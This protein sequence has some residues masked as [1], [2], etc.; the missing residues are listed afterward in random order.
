MGYDL[1]RGQTPHSGAFP[2][3]HKENTTEVIFPTTV[4]DE[5]VVRRAKGLDPR[6]KAVHNTL[7]GQHQ[8]NIQRSYQLV[9]MSHKP[10]LLPTR[11]PTER[12]KNNQSAG[13]GFFPS[14]YWNKQEKKSLALKLLQKGLFTN[15]HCYKT[16]R[17]W[18]YRQ[19]Y[20][21]LSSSSIIQIRRHMGYDLLRGQTPHSGAF[22]PKT[23]T[24]K[25]KILKKTLPFKRGFKAIWNGRRWGELSGR[26]I[27]QWARSS[28]LSTPWR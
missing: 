9:K 16:H 26:E 15:H 1:F 22:R 13:F 28:D 12:K 8:D 2:G 19:K 25:E 7:R 14:R 27:T 18:T 21:Y 10:V 20:L 3:L 23:Q 17:H 11:Y 24:R 6:V 5:K 4:W